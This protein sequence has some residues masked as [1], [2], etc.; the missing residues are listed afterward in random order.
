[1]QNVKLV[2]ISGTTKKAYPKTKIHDLETNS[3][4]KNIGDLYSGIT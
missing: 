3:K 2:D 4:T 1:M